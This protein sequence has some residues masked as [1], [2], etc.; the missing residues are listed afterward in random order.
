MNKYKERLVGLIIAQVVITIFHKYYETIY[1]H[2]DPFHYSNWT[3]YLALGFGFFVMGYAFF[4]SCPNCGAK[5]VFRGWSITDLKWPQDQ[6]YKCGC[7]I[8]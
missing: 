8:K 7:E 4:L 3:Y 6:C 2:E 1:L 5:Q